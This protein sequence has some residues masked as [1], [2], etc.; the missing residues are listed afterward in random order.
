MWA[1]KGGVERAVGHRRGTHPKH[2]AHVSDAGRV[3]TQR[4]V[5]CSCGLRRVE[6]ESYRK[7]GGMWA[8]KGGV[9]RAV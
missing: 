8:E 6:T 5:E 4:L 7:E 1:E 3:E 9:E 2:L